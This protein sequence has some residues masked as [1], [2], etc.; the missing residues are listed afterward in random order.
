MLKFKNTVLIVLFN[1]A[2]DIDKEFYLQLYESYFKTIIFYSDIPTN[3]VYLSDINYVSTNS[4][5]YAEH[6]FLHFY[7]KYRN[8]IEN[9]DGLFY[10]MDDNII[11]TNLLN[12]VDINKIIIAD[13]YKEIHPLENYSGWV[14]DLE[15]GKNN[16]QKLINDKEF[17]KYNINKFTGSFSDFFYL[18][19]K[20]LTQKIFE[21]FE[22]FSKHKVFLELAIPSVIY[23]LEFERNAFNVFKSS[24]LWNEDRKKIHDKIWLDN[25]FKTYL[26]IHPIKL[27]QDPKFK[28]ILKEKLNM[29]KCIVITTINKP[30]EQ[31]MFYT[32][33]TGWDL[34][35]V[36]D[37]KTDDSLYYNIDCIYLGL[38]E[39]EKEFPSL[40]DKIPLKSYTRKMF[41]YL[42]A[43]KN[44]YTVIYDTDDD[45]IYTEDMDFFE[46]NLIFRDN[47][48][49]LGSD[50]KKE[51]IH[52][53]TCMKSYQNITKEANC[54]TFDKR[55]NELYI[56]N[57]A[58]IHL[59]NGTANEYCISGIFRDIK[60]CSDQN[61]VNIYK[62]YTDE[63]IWP[64]GIPYNNKSIYVKPSTHDNITDMKVSI[65]Q[66]LVNNDPDVDAYYRI[67]I[68]NKSF[69]F[70]IDP[71]YDV[72]LDKYAVCPFNSQNTFWIDKSMFYAMYL[73]VTVS[74]RYTD[75]LRGFVAL[76]Q[77]W[78][79]NKTI[80]F[81][82]PTAIQE[83]NEHDLN[84][85][86]ESEESMY[87]TAEK[88]ISLLNLNKNATIV[89][90]YS[91]LCDEKIVDTFELIVLK[92]WLA[93]ID[94]YNK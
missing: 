62:I 21:L 10:T 44:K 50:I 8:L 17:Q 6:I 72:V 81:T 2:V 36:G 77:L 9:C 16:I 74:F 33:K 56:K 70:D 80:K 20:Y 58:N 19:K 1:F 32:K 47:I 78:K 38:K 14:W 7:N 75:I 24:I 18:P 67:N 11:N 28:Y 92:E 51:F 82:L 88:V 64:R 35:V 37:S 12:Q 29:K 49:F 65:I 22:L 69:N 87:K 45:N 53:F 86:F 31:I 15:F 85:D 48:D 40:Y 76:Y 41:G 91:I 39:Q 25:A 66:G 84:K 89:E 57:K 68:N 52:D 30:T 83:R 42:Y 79:N 26:F 34:I 60:I 59:K 94:Q 90:V 46:N 54:F 43:M 61:F 27:R 55:T 23:N 63:N 73:P 4:G 3:N 71:G 93:L 13:L 5:L